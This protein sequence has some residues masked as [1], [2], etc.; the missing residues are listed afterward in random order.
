MYAQSATEIDCLNTL[1]I[2]IFSNLCSITHRI[3]YELINKT[4][5]RLV[6]IARTFLNVNY[7]MKDDLEIRRKKK[8]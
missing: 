5:K 4:G 7:E 3:P 2:N 1:I 8:L 6:H